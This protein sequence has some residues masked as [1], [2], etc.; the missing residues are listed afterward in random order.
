MGGKHSFFN[1]PTGEITRRDSKQE[2]DFLSANTSYNTRLKNLKSG[3]ESSKKAGAISS[4]TYD[5]IL[6]GLAEKNIGTSLARRNVDADKILNQYITQYKGELEGTTAKGK[7][8]LTTQKLFE[9][10]VDQPGSR[11]TLLTPRSNASKSILGV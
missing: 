9:T 5:E 1:D 8:R 10:M 7:S 11:Q 4:A 6:K 2:Q 3:L